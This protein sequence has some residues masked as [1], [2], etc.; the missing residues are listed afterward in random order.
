MHSPQNPNNKVA[1]RLLIIDDEPDLREILVDLLSNSVAEIHQASDGIEGISKIQSI[2]FDAV[3]S[4][5]KMPKK[6][7]LDVLRWLRAHDQKIPFIIHTG[8]GERDFLS[9]LQH[10]GVF[11]IID[12]PWNEKHLIETVKQAI[13]YGMEQKS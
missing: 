8:Y 2:E 11:A 3:L 12:K 6:T 4:D 13:Q 1:G 9:E 10:L 5:E 7:G